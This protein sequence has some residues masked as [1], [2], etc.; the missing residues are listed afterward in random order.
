MPTNQR[1]DD[2]IESL[3]DT[4]LYS[5]GAYFCDSHPELIDQVIQQSVTIEQVGLAN[6]AQ[7]NELEIQEAFQTLLTGLAVRYYNA[8]VGT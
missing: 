7:E 4:N 2:F 3:M 8:I 5:I 1:T 6:F